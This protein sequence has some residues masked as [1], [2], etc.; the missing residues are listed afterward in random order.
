MRCFAAD[1][2]RETAPP[3][4]CANKIYSAIPLHERTAFL[5]VLLLWLFRDAPMI[6]FSPNTLIIFFSKLRF[7]EPFAAAATD[8]LHRAVGMGISL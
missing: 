4:A 7:R 6:H 3:T 2:Q 5:V 8:R 1:R